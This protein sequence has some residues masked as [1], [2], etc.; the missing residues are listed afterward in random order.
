METKMGLFKTGDIFFHPE[1]KVLVE[2]G[3]S[4]IP[5][6]KFK[7]PNTKNEILY[8]LKILNPDTLESKPWKSYWQDK[9]QAKLVKLEN[10]QAAKVLFKENKQW[11]S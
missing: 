11:K 7:K 10:M 8:R 6:T 4:T 2:I 9:M 1:Q 5:T 3:E